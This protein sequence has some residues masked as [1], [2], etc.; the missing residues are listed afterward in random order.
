ADRQSLLGR[1]SYEGRTFNYVECEACGSGICNPMPDAPLLARMYGLD[2]A[3]V[4]G[5]DTQE[6]PKE[7]GRV[8]DWLRKGPPGPVVDFGWG[9]GELLKAA[10]DMG[11]NAAGVELAEDVASAVSQRLGLRVVAASN[12][13]AV[14]GLGEIDV[15]H[16]GDVIEHLTEPLVTVGAFLRFVKPGGLVLAQG[17]LEGG[18]CLFAT[19][20]KAW[21]RLARPPAVAMAPYHVIQ[22]T[23]SGQRRYFERLGLAELEYRVTE[24]PW[25]APAR[26]RAG[27]FSRPRV[28]AL[29][30]LRR[31]SMLS[32]RARP[33][34]RGNR[35]FYAG[36]RA[37]T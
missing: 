9:Q 34:L 16:L 19:A 24:V 3:A 11:W 36:R 17:P 25:P 4:G 29:W 35:Y 1:V 21:H 30:S 13:A 6:D 27:D 22:A 31:M 28:F 15:V 33:G 18:P 12:E 7:P 5:D 32:S 20:L 2:Y 8:L 26:L 37:R 23:V 10:A 14:R